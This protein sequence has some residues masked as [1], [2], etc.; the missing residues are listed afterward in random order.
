GSAWQYTLDYLER[1]LS[2]LTMEGAEQIEDPHAPYLMLTATLGR[3]VGELHQALAS[4]GPDH[5]QFAPEQV[6]PGELAEW[7]ARV[8]RDIGDTYAALRNRRHQLPDLLLPLVDMLIERREQLIRR[9]SAIADLEPEFVKTRYHGDLH[10]GQ[11]LLVENDFVI[12]DFEGEPAR[13]M[14]ERQAKG[15]VLRDVAGMLRSF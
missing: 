9:V 5:P 1:Y 2:G 4:A 6:T 10:L 7:V 15:P 13:S 12:T 11:V 3:R 14:S 8:H